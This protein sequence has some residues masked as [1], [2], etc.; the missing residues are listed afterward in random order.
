MILLVHHPSGDTNNPTNTTYDAEISKKPIA[1]GEI[2]ALVFLK[3]N[4]LSLIKRRSDITIAELIENGAKIEEQN[5]IN[6]DRNK[7][8]VPHGT[9][10][11]IM[12]Q[13]PE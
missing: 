3:D 4:H 2:A 6:I 1:S 13:I 7:V 12:R 10:V 11:Y 5:D 8:L 9:A